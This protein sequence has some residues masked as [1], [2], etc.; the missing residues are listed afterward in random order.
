MSGFTETDSIQ[1][2]GMSR[3]TFDYICQCLPTRLLHQ[4]THLR[5]PISLKNGIGVGLCWLATGAGYR[6][7]SNLF[8]IAKS[9][10]CLIVHDFHQAVCHLLTPGYIKIP[11]DDLQEVI[12]GFRQ[13]WGFP[14]ALERLTGVIF[15]LLLLKRI[16]LTTSTPKDGTLLFCRGLLVISS[17]KHI[18]KYL[19]S[20]FFVSLLVLAI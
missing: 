11:Q 10:I 16:T 3:H 15:P 20:V 8:G 4:D 9:S 19:I 7:L 14:S 17:G 5:Q 2:F 1:N 18:M 13:R 12:Q 6:T